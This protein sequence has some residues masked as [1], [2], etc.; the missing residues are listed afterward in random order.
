MRKY[1]STY[2]K[3]KHFY[4]ELLGFKVI[5]ENYRKERDDYK[6][7]ACVD[8]P[9]VEKSTGYFYAHFQG[10]IDFTKE[11]TSFSSRVRALPF[12]LMNPACI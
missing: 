12:F 9:P 5:R 3:S 10:Y 1:I 11:T 2:E 6:I 4:V 7:F 8:S